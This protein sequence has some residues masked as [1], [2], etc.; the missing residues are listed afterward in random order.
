MK[1][2]ILL[3]IITLFSFCCFSQVNCFIYPEGS[4]SRKA[5]QT[6]DKAL[7][8]QQGSKA[9]QELLDKAIALDPNFAFAYFEKSIGFLKRG[10]L[11]QGL[12]ILNKAVALKPL[13]YLCYRAYWY[14]QYRN[15]DLCIKDLETYYAM[16]KAYLQFTPGGEKDMRIILGLAYAKKGDYKKGIKTI[17][18][19]INSYKTEDDFGFADYHSL[20]V[21]YV[22][23]KQY[24]KAITTFNKQIEINKDMVDTYYYLGLAYKGLNDSI[25]AEDYFKLALETFDD[26]SRFINRNAGFN[27]Y[28]SD[29]KK[30]INE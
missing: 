3:S 22:K 12:S 21:L 19:C 16:P 20:G 9:Q 25:K 29:I 4:N 18:N 7:E 15:Y 17:T 5:C 26:N 14:W 23:N 8:F 2:S 27:V 1:K 24:N 13:D 30:E 10:F 28:L 6:C 11:T